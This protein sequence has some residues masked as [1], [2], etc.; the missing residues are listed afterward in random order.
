LATIS[1]T[2]TYNL[3]KLDKIQPIVEECLVKLGMPKIDSH[4]SEQETVL[5]SSSGGLS[6]RVTLRERTISREDSQYFR[7]Q[8]KVLIEIIGSSNSDDSKKL[9]GLINDFRYCVLIRAARGGG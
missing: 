3:Y 8:P 7:G 6:L 5:E 9:Q 2:E 4:I 1:F